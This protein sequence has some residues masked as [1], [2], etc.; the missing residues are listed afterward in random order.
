[1]F[2]LRYHLASLAAVFVA[3]AVGIVIG[4]AIASGGGVDD[5]TV[6]VQGDQIRALKD[7][8]EAARERAD[9]SENQER[10][11]GDLM[12]EVYP[13]L[14][15]GRLE[16]RRIALL[17][18]G[19]V[20]GGIRSAV[21]KTLTDTGA[22]SSERV[23]ALELPIDVEELDAILAA[24]PALAELVGDARLGDLGEALAAEL[25]AGGETPLWSAL[26]GVLVGQRTGALDAPVDGV[27][28]VRSWTPEETDDPATQGRINQTEALLIGLLRGLDAQGVPTVGVESWTADPST[29]DAYRGLG[30]SSVDDVDRLP[31]RVALGLLLAGADPGHYGVKSSADDGV[32]PP[33]DPLTLVASA[34]LAG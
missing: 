21:E 18:L 2:D 13:T 17:F 6:A 27:V 23:A 14:M 9:R 19:P 11:I 5:A 31:G 1:M 28:V 34:S 26:S 25:V 8:L 4:V 10:A 3:I 7:E 22:G 16:N 29:I 12:E 20:D 33:L 32:A 30:I 24:D 15:A